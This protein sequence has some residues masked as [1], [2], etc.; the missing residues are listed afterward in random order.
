VLSNPL[1]QA[2]LIS[3]DAGANSFKLESFSLKRAFET[4]KVA[5]KEGS[6]AEP[7]ED[8]V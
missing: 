7:Q 6:A 5:A 2:L 4:R 8:V 3:Q 1:L